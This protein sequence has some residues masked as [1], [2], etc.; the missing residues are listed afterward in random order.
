MGRL[1]RSNTFAWVVSIVLHGLFFAVFWGVVLREEATVRRVIIPEARLAASP[2]SA[3]P[4]DEQPLKVQVPA[5][6]PMSEDKPPELEDVPLAALA[7]DEPEPLALPGERPVE[8]AVSLTGQVTGAASDRAPVS[9]FFGQVGNAYKV[10][11]VVDVSASLMI[12]IDQIVQQMRDSIDGLIPTQRFHI[13]LARPQKVEELSSRRLVPAI[14]RYKREATD[15][16]ATIKRIPAPGK[17]DPIEAMKRAFAMEP[18]L[19][20]FLSDGDYPDIEQD[21]EAELG[22]LNE[23]GGVAITTIGF[24]PSPKP[25]ALLERIARNHSGHFRMVG[26]D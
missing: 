4:A 2:G 17:A 25:R 6:D 26:P 10:V 12:Y 16:L 7:L 8:Q 23:G 18:E 9:R 5:I 15:F 1:L 21:L 24:D 13:V 11:Y 19:I 20:Y 3:E 14:H 22:K